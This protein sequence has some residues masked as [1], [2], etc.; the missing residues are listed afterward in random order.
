MELTKDL[1][2]DLTGAKYGRCTLRKSEMKMENATESC[3]E[4]RTL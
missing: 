1:H 3:E 2:R 4:G